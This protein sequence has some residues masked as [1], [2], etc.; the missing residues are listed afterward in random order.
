MRSLFGFDFRRPI[1]LREREV[2]WPALATSQRAGGQEGGC[3]RVFYGVRPRLD[4]V[5]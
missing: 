3:A 2:C 5:E 1:S 4:G